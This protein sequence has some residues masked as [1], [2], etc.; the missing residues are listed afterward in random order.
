MITHSH[1]ST[2]VVGEGEGGETRYGRKGREN[3]GGQGRV[4]YRIVGWWWRRRL[5]SLL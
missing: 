5:N 1:G 3:G 2:G 4:G